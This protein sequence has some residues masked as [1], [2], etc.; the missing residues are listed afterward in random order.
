MAGEGTILKTDII[1]S[2]ELIDSLA[3][4]ADEFERIANSAAQIDKALPKASFGELSKL[5]S[6]ANE[7]TK[8]LTTTTKE[9]QSIISLGKQRYK[10]EAAAQKKAESEKQ[11][12]LN[13]TAALSKQRSAEYIKQLRAEQAEEKRA[14]AQR[15]RLTELVIKARQT[16]VG[17]LTRLNAMNNLYKEHMKQLNVLIP[18]QAKKY[19]Q[20]NKN[21]LANQQSMA[22]MAMGAKAGGKQFNMLQ[23]Q[24]MQVTR[25][26]PAFAYGINVG[27]G[28]LSNNL[29]MLFDEID[30][31]RKANKLL[32]SEG[33]ATTSVLKQIGASIISWQTALVVG[34]T[35][36]TLYG[37]D[38]AEWIKKLIN[39]EDAVLRIVD[40]QKQLNSAHLEGAKNAQDEIT[41]LKILYDTTQ[42]QK[43]SMEDRIGAV[44]ELQKLYPEYLGNFTKESI[45]AGDAYS[46][47][48]LLN[49]SIQER[50]KSLAVFSKLVANNV[51]SVEKEIEASRLYADILKKEDERAA[52]RERKRQGGFSSSREID[53]NI[54]NTNRL[55]E[56]ILNLRTAW[57]KANDTV[58]EYRKA[59]EELLKFVD[60]GS[61]FSGG[62][63]DKKAAEDYLQQLEILLNSTL[64]SY[65]AHYIKRKSEARN[66]AL[67]LI[68]IEKEMILNLLYEDAKYNNLSLSQREE[69][70]AELNALGDK[71]R[72]IESDRIISNI[73]EQ[74]DLERVSRQKQATQE[75]LDAKS[76]TIEKKKINI[77]AA[78][79]LLRIEYDAQ[80]QIIDNLNTTTEAKAKAAEEQRKIEEQLQKVVR[81]GTVE[82]ERLKREA[83]S[84]TLSQMQNIINAGFEF[85]AQLNANAVADNERRFELETQAA[86]EN[87]FKQLVAERKYERESAKLKRKQAIADKANA[88]TNAII[89]TALGVTN[90]TAKVATI[91]LIP[92]ILTTGA[93]QLATIL[94]QPIP[95]FA[96]GVDNF[97]GGLAIVGDKKG[98]PTKAGGSEL[99]LLPSG[100]GI[101][102][103]G[104][105]T[106]MDFPRGTE[107]IPNIDLQRE[108]ANNAVRRS[109]DI[110]DMSGTN[111]HLKNIEKNT[112]ES[113]LYENGYKI[114]RRKGF[115]GKYRQI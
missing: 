17:S 98:D 86:G 84:E 19:A 88:A 33:K 2:D 113:V 81:G 71:W 57:G 10:E 1:Q 85:G 97:G 53:E 55:N 74:A 91:P 107:I 68:E 24:I 72:K 12:E 109:Y 35:L 51:A 18:E 59:N 39:G 112:G 62:G 40:A 16:E 58:I 103:P 96:E 14:A 34:V 77:K 36:L 6:Q 80:Q 15:Q 23:W 44:N 115:V 79:D 5:A 3:R 69:L 65:K 11:K 42:N 99:A 83:F 46:A 45:L 114:K 64:D 87:K 90:A 106:V 25:E 111:R 30:K 13:R 75:L 20:L 63:N 47:Y 52:L 67:E 56:E 27:I 101:I 29:P 26:M 105:P 76:K 8:K 61:L 31:V 38:I 78:V 110:V 32:A 100:Q 66:D 82:T 73:Y 93:I 7:E 48:T 95:A 60:V 54:K 102:T 50:A 37:K 92:F 89:N 21:I 108:L 9:F 49:N 4:V 104:I 28:A 22:R 70:F 43:E 41:K 94:A